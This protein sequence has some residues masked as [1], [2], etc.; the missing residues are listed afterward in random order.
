MATRRNGRWDFEAG[1]E[2]EDD[3]EEEGEGG[4][5][6]PV[7]GEEGMLKKR[8]RS[9]LRISSRNRPKMPKTVNDTAT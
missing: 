7:A 8:A 6:W 1:R 5:C 4:R 2:V 3:E 9:V